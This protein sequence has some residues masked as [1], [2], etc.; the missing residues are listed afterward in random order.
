MAKSDNKKTQNKNRKS[1]GDYEVGFSK[2]PKHARFKKGKS[3]NPKGRPKGSKNMATLLGEV[4][5]SKVAVSVNGTKSEL[6]YRDA[7][8]KQMAAKALT[9][10]MNDMVKFMNAIDQ[11]APVEFESAGNPHNIFVRFIESDGNGRP[12]NP[13][14]LEPITD[15]SKFK[16][17]DTPFG[18]RGSASS[19][20]QEPSSD[21]TE[22]AWQASGIDDEPDA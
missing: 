8:V 12:A 2:S 9:G 22:E 14:D 4:L 7:I 1:K 20:E 10:T 15:Y 17:S 18:M 11:H 3:G 16:I 13:K 6:P 19:E 5:N 21:E